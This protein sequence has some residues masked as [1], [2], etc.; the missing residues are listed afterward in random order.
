M[1]SILQSSLPIPQQAYVLAVGE[2]RPSTAAAYLHLG[3]EDWIARVSTDA[4]LHCG[5]SA[6]PFGAAAAASLAAAN[7]FR[8]VFAAELPNTATDTDCNLSLLTCNHEHQTSFTRVA[9][10]ASGCRIAECRNPTT[11]L[12]CFRPLR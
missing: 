2:A 7:L 9:E 4:T 3:S 10:N 8:M 11:R 6:N 5:D 1:K 12:L